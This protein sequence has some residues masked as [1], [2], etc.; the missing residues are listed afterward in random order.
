[1]AAA[2]L[3]EHLERCLWRSCEEALRGELLG[4]RR[5]EESIQASM[6]TLREEERR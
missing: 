3:E 6:L 5:A 4:L 1:M 2:R